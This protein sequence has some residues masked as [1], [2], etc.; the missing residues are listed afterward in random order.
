MKYLLIG[1][2][3]IHY[4]KEKLQI[5]YSYQVIKK[6]NVDRLINNI[7]LISADKFLLSL[8]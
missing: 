6:S 1:K 2:N 7:R 5:P 3:N 4:F 8:V